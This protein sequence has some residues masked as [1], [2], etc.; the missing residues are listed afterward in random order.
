[1]P[2]LQI[3]KNPDIFVEYGCAN[4]AAITNSARQAS[5]SDHP[6]LQQDY[7]PEPAKGC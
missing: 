5:A 3:R 6:L 7:M 2:G 4:V 1:M